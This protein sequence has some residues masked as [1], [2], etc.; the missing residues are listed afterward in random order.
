MGQ[1][2]KIEK[3]F[4]HYSIPNKIRKKLIKDT[5]ADEI[6][7][8]AKEKDLAVKNVREITDKLVDDFLND[9]QLLNNKKYAKLKEKGIFNEKNL[10]LDIEFIEYIYNES[11]KIKQMIPKGKIVYQL[12]EPS[13]KEEVDKLV[14][15]VIENNEDIKKLTDAY[16]KAKLNIATLY[17]DKNLDEQEKKYKKEIEKI[18]ANKILGTVKSINRLENEF[19]KQETIKVKQTELINQS[20]ID[21]ISLFYCKNEKE[22]SNYNIIKSELSK[23]GK[24]EI[25]LKN[26]DKGYEH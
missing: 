12:L 7:E 26:Q 2:S 16:I 4:Q 20:I 17:S 3:N 14:S 5:F 25:Y 18:I 13:V 22:K 15:Y 19:K 6:L 23:D 8:Y 10:K 9:I 21:L 11:Y 1:I 24:K